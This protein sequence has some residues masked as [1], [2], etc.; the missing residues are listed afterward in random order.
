MKNFNKHSIALIGTLAIMA[1]VPIAFVAISTK[2]S[3][4]PAV[5]QAKADDFFT[6]GNE[7]YE[8]GDYQEAVA[9][10][11]QAIELNPNFADAYNGRGNA[12]GD[13]GDKQ[14][15]LADYNEALRINPNFAEAYYNR[16]VTH[17]ELGDKPSALADY[18]EA[19][20]INPNFA[21][22]YHNRGVTRAEL[23]DNQGAIQDYHK[24]ADLYQQQGK[25]DNYQDA[26][27]RIRE[28][29]KK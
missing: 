14:G 22:V 29:Q 16:G 27:N 12:H 8:Q 3:S 19:L 6:Q 2:V 11:A 10:Y 9:T 5:T 20:R 4:S 28:L 24:A 7:K 13:S 26:L 15:A 25:K 17:A 1:T 23:G 21:Q 18:N